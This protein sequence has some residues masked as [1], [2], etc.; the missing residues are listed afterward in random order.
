LEDFTT[1][2][3]AHHTKVRSSVNNKKLKKYQE[4]SSTSSKILREKKYPKKI[5]ASLIIEAA[6]SL[7]KVEKVKKS[8]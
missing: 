4:I 3:P 2:N 1:L 5:S 7:P 8:H 6:H